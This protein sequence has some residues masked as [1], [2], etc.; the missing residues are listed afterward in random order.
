MIKT[1]KFKNKKT[2]EIK[3]QINIFE[4]GDYEEVKDQPQKQKGIL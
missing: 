2:G 1:K 4:L 3:T